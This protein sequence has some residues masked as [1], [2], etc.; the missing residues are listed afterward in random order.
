VVEV[1]AAFDNSV[2]FSDEVFI[3]CDPPL[4][5]S[6]LQHNGRVDINLV[7]DDTV[8]HTYTVTFGSLTPRS[9]TLQP[10]ASARVTTT[11]RPDG[12]LLVTVDRDG[13]QVFSETVDIDCDLDQVSYARSTVGCLFRNGRVD[14]Y[15]TNDA[16][17]TSTYVVNFGEL[18][19]RERTLGPNG[20]T[21]VTTTGRPDGPLSVIV[22]RDGVRVLQQTIFINCD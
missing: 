16:S 8:T 12:P 3:S 22:R 14:I 11:G 4:S 18:A 9:R 21:R 5:S 17:G 13:V 2:V 10:R 1:V 19:P 7:N 15:L 6:C 20:A